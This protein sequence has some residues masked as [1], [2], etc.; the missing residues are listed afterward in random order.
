MNHSLRNIIWIIGLSGCICTSGLTQE[1][2]SK[3]ISRPDYITDANINQLLND[4]ELVSLRL[5]GSRF[6]GSDN[7]TDEGVKTLVKLTHLKELALLGQ[8][9]SDESLKLIG[10]MTALEKLD[11]SGCQITED[12]LKHLKGLVNLKKLDADLTGTGLVHLT[13]LSGIEEINFSYSFKL[14]PENI[15]YLCQF[16]N[17]RRLHFPS[18]SQIPTD[19]IMAQLSSLTLLESL[20]IEHCSNDSMRGGLSEKG[21]S[22][23]ASFRKLTQLE[24]GNA[25]GITPSSIKVISK[26]EKLRSLKLVV[27]NLDAADL[28]SL[29]DLKELEKL[30]LWGIDEKKGDLNF[31]S[32]LQKLQYFRSNLDFTDNQFQ[33]LCEARNL[34]DLNIQSDQLSDDSQAKLSQLTHLTSLSIEGKGF[35]KNSIKSISQLP[36]LTT[37]SF[38]RTPLKGLMPELMML[39]HL[40][41][42]QLGYDS[43]NLLTKEEVNKLKSNLQ[44]IKW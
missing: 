10:T 15:K 11:L 12:G 16:P 36:N 42:L 4:P 40:K 31:L 3:K 19:E 18:S 23:L 27:G 24:L 6:Y 41:S 8:D 13:N 43:D 2:E 21:F 44:N 28:E 35:G 9:V 5:H 37:L 25:Y 7:L 14:N 30:L 39:K 34:T 29:A 33:S 26:L 38:H 32:H 1:I 22:H 17:L 20:E